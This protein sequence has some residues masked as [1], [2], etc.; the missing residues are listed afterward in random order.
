MRNWPCSRTLSEEH[1]LGDLADHLDGIAPLVSKTG[2]RW[3]YAVLLT[4]RNAIVHSS[5]CL[6]PERADTPIAINLPAISER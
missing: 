2:G 5:S 4:R 3:R 1:P 6:V